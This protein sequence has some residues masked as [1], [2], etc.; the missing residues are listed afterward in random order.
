MV[1]GVLV[2]E[3]VLVVEDVLAIDILL[4]LYKLDGKY[5]IIVLFLPQCV[6]NDLSNMGAILK[7]NQ[8]SASQNK[9]SYWPI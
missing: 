8:N 5:I 6:P 9:F 2:V 3:C 7:N 1:E 4:C